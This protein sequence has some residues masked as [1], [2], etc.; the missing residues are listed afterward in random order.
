MKVLPKFMWNVKKEGIQGP[1]GVYV[2]RLE[3]ENGD[4]LKRKQEDDI[5]NQN[6]NPKRLLFQGEKVQIDIKYVPRECIQFDSHGIRYYQITAIDKYSRKRHCTLVD[7]KSVTHTA[8]FVLDLEE[9][10]GFKIHKVQ[11]DNGPEF[12]NDQEITQKK[13][14]FEEALECLGIRYQNTRP[15]SP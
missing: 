4:M 8:R 6:G 10:L 1:T 9:Q 7:E 14:V 13:T 3:T 2:N 11:T 12:V 5:R 15:Y